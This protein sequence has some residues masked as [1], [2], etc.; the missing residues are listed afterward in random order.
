MNL[1]L[2]DPLPTPA[3]TLCL[4]WPPTPPHRPQGWGH[5]VRVHQIDHLCSTPINDSNYQWSI[6]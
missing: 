6:L 2:W 1:H 4:A 3:V 5:L